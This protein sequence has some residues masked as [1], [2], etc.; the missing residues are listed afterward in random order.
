[1]RFADMH[2]G[3]T[4]QPPYCEVPF[5]LV[6]IAKCGGTAVA[7]AVWPHYDMTEI[8]WFIDPEEWRSGDV[9]LSGYRC[10]LGHAGF[11]TGRCDIGGPR[12]VTACAVRESVDH[13]L[14]HYFFARLM[15]EN[16]GRQSIFT[17]DEDPVRNLEILLDEPSLPEVLLNP[18]M[19]MLAPL[20]L[21]VNSW[22]RPSRGRRPTVQLYEA[23]LANLSQID[24]LGVFECLGDFAA[25][26]GEALGL[27]LQL[28]GVY[29]NR[30]E[31]ERW[32][33]PEHPS[34]ESIRRKILERKQWDAR[35]YDAVVRRLGEGGME[36]PEEG[37][38]SATTGPGRG[39]GS[40]GDGAAPVVPNVDQAEAYCGDSCVLIRNAK[41]ERVAEQTRAVFGDNLRETPDFRGFLGA[42]EPAVAGAEVIIAL[43]DSTTANV[44]N[45]PFILADK[46]LRGSNG[47]VVNLADWARSS[48]AHVR[49]IEYYLDWLQGRF[50]AASTVVLMIGMRDINERLHLY[51]GF[52]SQGDRRLLSQDEEDLTNHR[53]GAE[54]ARLAEEVPAEWEAASEW[55]ARR[56]VAGVKAMEQICADAGS[57]FLAILEP[58]SYPDCS[59]SY[60]HALHRAYRADAE[61]VTTPFEQW[62]N[63]HRYVRDPSIFGPHDH[64]PALNELRRLWQQRSDNPSSGHYLDWSGLFR[65]TVESCFQSQFDGV[66]YNTLGAG[67]IADAVA[68]SLAASREGHAKVGDIE[69]AR[70]RTAVDR[71]LDSVSRRLAEADLEP[72]EIDYLYKAFIECYSPNQFPPAVEERGLELWL[73][74]FPDREDLRTRHAE[75]V[76]RRGGAGRDPAAV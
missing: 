23:A 72:R 28:P 18:Q 56:I 51:D 44:H 20:E 11:D 38:Q 74:L 61:A 70:R 1:M 15:H 22:G 4:T 55:I 60:L 45:W 54:L 67:L 36:V 53:Y 24:V 41:T 57:R 33:S 6:H 63:S 27:S 21:S 40:S 5:R 12:R 68:K 76:A 35:L 50:A 65:G 62:L 32:I 48:E 2:P 10:I 25:R 26:V 14:S 30:S 31:K 64:R 69:A 58:S 29:H 66:H 9:D 52:M 73:E 13:F 16:S 42:I 75:L 37:S 3:R 39:S 34:Y 19:Y 47:V 59:P 43:G 7:E 49:V 46:H 71:W 8:F 17:R